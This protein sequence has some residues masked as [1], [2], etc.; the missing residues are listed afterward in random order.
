MPSKKK[1]P[2]RPVPAA[3][4]EFELIRRLA[5][6]LNETGLSEIELDRRG[7]KV[8]V[9]RATASVTT[10]VPSQTSMQH[11][12]TPAAA[13][14]APGRAADADHPGTVK[15]PMVGTVYRSPAPGVPPFI[16]VGVEVK[17]GQV[18]LVIEAMKTMNQIPAPRAGR[19]THVFVDNG[20]PVEYGEPLVVI[21]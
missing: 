5:D 20:H 7:V 10:A 6:I 8:R 18:L 19:V 12:S 4:P 1:T 2:A 17:E 14:V 3:D 21:E 11:V 15:S 9:A 13:T 16:D